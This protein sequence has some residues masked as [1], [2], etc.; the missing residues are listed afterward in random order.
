MSEL[1]VIIVTWNVR[2]LLASC[3][4]TLLADLDRSH[5]QA[6]VWVVDNASTDGTPHLVRRRFPRVQLIANDQNLGFAAANNLVLDRLVLPSQAA[7]RPPFIWLLNPDTEVQPGAASTLLSTLEA[8]PRSG[9]VGAKLL[10]PNGSLQHGAFRFPGL[11]QLAFELFPLPSPLYGT[12]LNGRYPR[13]LYDGVDS[14]P[15]DHPLGASMLL[16][17]ATV[18]DVGLLDP[19]YHMYC[20]EI[21]WCW[22][23]REAG[24]HARCAPTARVIHH[25]GRST[26]QVAL[27]SFVNLWRSRARL[28]ARHQPAVTWLLAR[29]MVRLGM[30]RRMADASP[31]VVAACRDVLRAWENAR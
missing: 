13:R 1:A 7:D 4:Q 18:D 25:A 20:E 29:A 5:L 14:F 26:S 3:L 28:Y 27:P 8:H 23:M 12:A 22:R 11:I 31:D 19:G 16:R 17:T 10:Y 21:D 9:V 24:W 2:G 15:I 6:S 30:R